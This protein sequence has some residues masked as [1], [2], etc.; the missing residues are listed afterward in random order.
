MGISD[1]IT[2][3]IIGLM[4]SFAFLVGVIAIGFLM[5]RHRSFSSESVR[6]FIHI[7]VSNWY[8]IYSQYLTRIE[9][10]LIG[11]I[12]FIILNSLATFCGWTRYFKLNNKKRNYGLIYFPISL[13]ILIIMD[14]MSIIPKY[15]V[16]I[17][18]LVM[19]YGDG[20]A[21]IMGIKFGR[22]HITANKTYFGSIT[23]FSVTLCI[24]Y[25]F[26]HDCKLDWFETPEKAF[27]FILLSLLITFI[28]IVTPF[29]LDN[30]TVPLSTALGIHFLSKYIIH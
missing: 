16:G 25:L 29:G 1:E 5:S 20:L 24:F 28:E 12:A 11:P 4:I 22:K 15:V 3:N 9:F 6:K 10:S 14:Y 27:S 2:T 30:I 21:A 18:C 17:S 13:V 8:F 19:G 7:G 23:M 26:S